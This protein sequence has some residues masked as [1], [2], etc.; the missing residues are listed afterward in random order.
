MVFL[1]FQRWCNDASTVHQRWVNDGESAFELV[2]RGP[3]GHFSVFEAY[4]RA[5]RGI[6]RLSQAKSRQRVF[7]AHPNARNAA[8]S[9]D[10]SDY[11][12]AIDGCAHSRHAP[13]APTH[14]QPRQQKLMAPAR[15]QGSQGLGRASPISTAREPITRSRHP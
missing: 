5:P 4:F 7:C 11:D 1:T 9:G 8:H 10:C 15:S 12:G 3:F 14:R 13:L 6:M 2:W